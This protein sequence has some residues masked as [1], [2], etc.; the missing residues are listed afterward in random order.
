MPVA[1]I[2]HSMAEISRCAWEALTEKNSNPILEWSWLELLESSGSITPE[3]GWSPRHLTLWEKGE[4]VAA[5]PLYLRSHSWGDFVFDFGF[6]QATHRLRIPWYPKLVGMS[7]VTPVPGWRVLVANGYDADELTNTWLD[8]AERLA[9]EEGAV[10]IQFNFTEPDWFSSWHSRRTHPG[11]WHAWFHQN[12][13]FEN[14]GLDDFDSYLARFDKNQR[15]NIIRERRKFEQAGLRI[16]MVPGEEIP[17]SWFRLMARVYHSTNERFGDFAARFLEPEFFDR[18]D[19][20]R[21]LLVFSASIP[22]GSEEPLAL[23][24]LLRKNDVLLGRYWGELEWRD[25]QY[26]NVCYYGPIEWAIREGITRFDPGAGSHLKARRGFVSKKNLSIH[27]F[28]DRNAERL[29][30]SFLRELNTE[31]QTEIDGLNASVPFKSTFI[32]E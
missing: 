19:K 10:S 5:A 16:R 20:I 4:L 6:A 18:L 11:S 32:R 24:L 26:F 3:H 27:R 13:L 21:P 7:P 22:E 12:Y 23:G 2:Y 28:F 30:T 31:E 14:N 17:E 8:E 15:R 29:F 25:C 9:Q 1:R